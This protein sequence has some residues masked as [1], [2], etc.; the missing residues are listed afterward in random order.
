MV[1]GENHRETGAT[2]YAAKA[3]SDSSD[4]FSQDAAEN[5]KPKDGMGLTRPKGEVEDKTHQSDGQNVPSR[6][7]GRAAD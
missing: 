5:R 2:K 4:Q 7:G 3:G 6:P 1:D